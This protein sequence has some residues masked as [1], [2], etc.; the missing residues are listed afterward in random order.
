M[1]KRDRHAAIVIIVKIAG[2]LLAGWAAVGWL[3][4]M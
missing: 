2:W 1:D 4:K 3:G